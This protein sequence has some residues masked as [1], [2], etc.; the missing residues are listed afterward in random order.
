M[1][2]LIRTLG[3]CATLL[4]FAFPAMG[5]SLEDAKAAGKL[6]EGVDGYLHVVNSAAG[7]EMA[8]L[9]S[10]INEK[11]KEKY[12]GIATKQ[13]IALNAVETQ[14]GTKLVDRASAGQYV[15]TSN[16]EWTKK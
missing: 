16:G 10:S 12:Q 8:A 6:G 2:R 3:I 13:G 1:Q 9:A 4:L 7:A 11:R 5:D 14:A 15:M